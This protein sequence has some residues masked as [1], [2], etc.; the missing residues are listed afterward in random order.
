MDHFSAQQLCM[1]CN[2]CHILASE[3]H[4]EWKARG[5]QRKV[6]YFAQQLCITSKYLASVVR[7]SCGNTPRE[8]IQRYTVNMIAQRLRTTHKT[9][10][11]ISVEMDFSN[12]SYFGKFF[13]KYM[14]CSPAQYRNKMRHDS[15][16]HQ[17][18][19]AL[20]PNNEV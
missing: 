3:R 20:V 14:G 6:E 2:C 15:M 16:S 17:S 7:D 19:A 11:E 9:I 10:K 8:M 18:T 1:D 4:G 12:E 13:K 5:R